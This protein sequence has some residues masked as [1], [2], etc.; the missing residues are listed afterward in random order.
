MYPG[1]F[2]YLTGPTSYY[3][4]KITVASPPTNVQVLH[5]ETAMEK[6]SLDDKQQF[7]E[8]TTT[9]GKSARQH[10]VR[11]KRKEDTGHSSY[12]ILFCT[13][14][15]ELGSTV[16]TASLLGELNPAGNHGPRNQQA[17][18]PYATPSLN[19]RSYIVLRVLNRSS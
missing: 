6:L 7:R 4:N 1:H 18:L 12:P 15:R 16:T 13:Q 3:P 9:F 5:L 2:H 14:P 10:T 17:H 19:L 8:F 11:Y